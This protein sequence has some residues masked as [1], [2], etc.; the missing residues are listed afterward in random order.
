MFI[1]LGPM[2]ILTFGNSPLQLNLCLTFG[3]SPLQAIES[4]PPPLLLSHHTLELKKITYKQPERIV[5]HF[6]CLTFP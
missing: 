6:G 5:D 2:T 3:N 4:L 1:N